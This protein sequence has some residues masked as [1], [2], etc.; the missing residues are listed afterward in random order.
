M[1]LTHRGDALRLYRRVNGAV[2][3]ET[4][5]FTPFMLV[6]DAGLLDGVDGIVDVTKLEGSA[7]FRR[8]VRFR[9][10][11]D[12]LAARDRCRERSGV[13]PG[14]PASPYRLLGDAVQ[15]FLLLTGRTSFEGLGF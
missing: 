3:A 13:A 8:L 9:S 5:P 12:A 1:T 7:A 10:W 4:V 6:A 15:Q 14:A 2:I 11:G